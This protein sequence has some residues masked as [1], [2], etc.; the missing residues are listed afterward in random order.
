VEILDGLYYSKEHEWVRVEGDKA[1]VGITD[2]AQHHLGDIVFVELPEVDAEFS[3]DERLGVIESVK[4]VAD[5]HCP[6]SGQVLEVNGDLEDAPES[7]NQTPYEAW[8]AVLQLKN[9]DELQQLMDAE[10]YRNFVANL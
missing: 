4:A 2:Y 5:V 3:A 1:H 7:V 6:V 8:I 10:A 9:R